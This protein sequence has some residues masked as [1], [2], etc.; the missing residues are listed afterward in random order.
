MSLKQ[1]M[2]RSL[3]GANLELAGVTICLCIRSANKADSEIVY[4]TL[5]LF[6]AELGM[7]ASLV[8]K[9]E[10]ALQLSGCFGVLLW[11][12]TSRIEHH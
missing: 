11:D 10:T 1:Q 12:Y 2:T 7:I 5:R 8:K 6:E 3:Q 4:A 9:D